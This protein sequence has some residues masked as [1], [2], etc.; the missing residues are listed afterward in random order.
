MNALPEILL[1]GFGNPGRQDDGLGPALA[2]AV[3]HLAIPGVVVDAN[4]QLTVE[5]AALAVEYGTIIFADAARVGPAPFTFCEIV[6]ARPVTFSSHSVTPQTVLALGQ[7]LFGHCCN[8][9]L[10]G[11]RGYE[12]DEFGETLSPVAQHNL[13]RA[14]TF[15]ERVLRERSLRGAAQRYTAA[16]R[17]GANPSISLSQEV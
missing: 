15:I 14:I 11:I 13:Q 2:A 8:G 17:P 16:E 4:Y 12:F 3:E 5:D 10:L 1:I 6:P 9:Y 7:Q